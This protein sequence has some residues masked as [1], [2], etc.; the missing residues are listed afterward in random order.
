MNSILIQSIM[1]ICFIFT[2]VIGYIC[3]TALLPKRKYGYKLCI[4][5]IIWTSWL[6]CATELFSLFHILSFISVLICWI[7]YI[8]A[9]ILIIRFR[10]PGFN[11]VR[12]LTD[13]YRNA[14][15]L[16]KEDSLFTILFSVFFFIA[17]R[18][19]F[20]ALITAPYNWDS[21]TYHLSR[22]MFWIQNRSIAYYETNISRQ[23]ISPILGECINLHTILLCGGDIFVNM[24]QYFSSCG[25]LVLI[26]S[27]LTKFGVSSRF[28][29]TGNLILLT[30]NTFFTESLST[31]VD[32]IGAFYLLIT[33]YM[34]I[35]LI[36]A[37]HIVINRHYI[38]H[39][40]VLGLS[41]GYIY[42][43]KSNAAISAAIIILFVFKYRLVKHDLLK[44]LIYS[45]IIASTF[46][47]GTAMPTFIRNHRYYGDILASRYVGNIG[48]GTFSPRL[49]LLNL[50]KNFAEVAISPMNA[51]FWMKAA[52]KLAIILNADINSPDIA[53]D[54]IEFY[55]SYSA[56]NM[57]TA[58]AYVLFPLILIATITGILRLKKHHSANDILCLIM[59]LQFYI[60]AMAV[61]WQ[62]WVIRLLLPS[63]V[64]CL[65]PTTYFIFS[66][67]NKTALIWLTL[68]VC[69][70]SH[71]ECFNYLK[72]FA[73][74][75]I[76]KLEYYQPRFNR[77]FLLRGNADP[78]NSMCDIID[79]GQ[80]FGNIGLFT[81]E[82]SY[83][84]PVLARYY[85]QKNMKNV[86]LNED[87]SNCTMN[88]GFEPD[89]IIAADIALDSDKTYFCNGRPYICVWMDTELIPG[90]YS[91]WIKND[92][93][94][95]L[96]Q[97][98]R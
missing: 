44:N 72:D 63:L 84:Y 77:Y 95:A 48:I 97:L 24:L 29:L 5:T 82:D 42:I 81:S 62:P 17:L 57:D 68:I 14:L 4:N 52:N 37:E 18:G 21:M 69:T 76:T 45:C 38:F 71:Y 64:V 79:D 66:A 92:Y 98:V 70:F 22:I 89:A 58:S 35:E 59:L 10:N 55:L 78:Y 80:S 8:L 46:S 7:L 53:L 49:V 56:Y 34:L 51:S 87:I 13:S 27:I 96:N 30:A 28:A 26:Y 15:A 83:Q 60:T 11:P 12:S 9:N 19:F 74:F 86:I 50:I 31:Q 20:L 47:A 91:L 54:K 25:C 90:N 61:R 93:I 85:R 6:Y 39:F 65:I 32:L 3:I 88:S 41:C 75:D 23:L 36:D 1:F 40:I 73:S 94:K 16:L 67:F 43:C 2:Y 33:V